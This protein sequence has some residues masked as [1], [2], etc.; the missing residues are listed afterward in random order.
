MEVG[1]IIA[2]LRSKHKITQR[3]LA[4]EINVSPGVI[5]MWETNKRF[6]SYEYI[7]ALADYFKISTDVLFEKDRKINTSN[8]A[9]IVLQPNERKILDIYM[10]LD[11]DNKDILIGKGKELL[12]EQRK[13][14]RDVVLPEKQA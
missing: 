14:K 13:E 7:L 8:Y 2:Q 5:G 6:P 4:E 10:N 12:K 11:E 3:K 1:H 9:P